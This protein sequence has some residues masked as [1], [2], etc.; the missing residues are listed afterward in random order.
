MGCT[1]GAKVL[2][3]GDEYVL[4]K[5]K[6]LARETFDDELVV[7]PS[8]FGVRG[9]HLPAGGERS[10]DVLSGFSIGVNEHGVAACNSH[11]T[12]IKDGLNYDDLTELAV[13]GVSTAAA[14]ADAVVTQAREAGYNWSNIIIADRDQVIVVEIADDVAVARDL[15]EIAYSNRHRLDH[16]AGPAAEPDA[17]CRR[18]T[19]ALT[20]ARGPEDVFALLRSHEGKAEASSICAHNES[21]TVC[22][23]YSYVLHWQGRAGTFYVCRGNP[24]TGEYVASPLRFPLD[25]DS[26]LRLYP[27][28]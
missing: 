18:A 7:T 11:V 5:N 9:L 20:S 23:V 12:S 24:C 27:R 8:V 10:A 17:R 21:R 2:Q 14:G 1:I 15:V 25:A 19:Q 4:F 3:Q 26:V 22:T 16:R 6:D 13:A 28:G